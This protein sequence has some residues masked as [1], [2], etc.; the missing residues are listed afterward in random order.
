M[1][2]LWLFLGRYKH[3]VTLDGTQKRDQRNYCTHIRHGKPMNLLSMGDLKIAASPKSPPSMNDSSQMWCP[4]NFLPKFQA[5]PPKR[6]LPC[7]HSPLRWP[8][9]SCSFRELPGSFTTKQAC[10]WPLWVS[11]VDSSAESRC[12][13][14][15]P[16]VIRE[17]T[18][19]LMSQ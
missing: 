12:L 16:A 13:R 9:E 15:G 5:A 10:I 2:I 19:N 4:W 11:L 1:D 18:L 6:P 3:L 14:A 8:C 7:N 17:G